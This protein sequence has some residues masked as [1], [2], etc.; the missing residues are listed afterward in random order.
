MCGVCLQHHLG[1]DVWNPLGLE[2]R[3]ASGSVSS[4][5]TA[6]ASSAESSGSWSC[7]SKSLVTG[8]LSRCT[9]RLL[10]CGVLFRTHWIRRHCYGHGTSD[11]P[12]T[13]S[14]ITIAPKVAK[15][16]TLFMA[17]RT[18]PRQRGGDRS[19]RQLAVHQVFMLLLWRSALG[20]TQTATLLVV[21]IRGHLAICTSAENRA[22]EDWC[23]TFKVRLCV[24]DV[25][26]QKFE[27]SLRED[28][29]R[30]LLGS[31][32]ASHSNRTSGAIVT[33]SPTSSFRGTLK[34]S[35]ASHRRLLVDV[36]HISRG[37]CDGQTLA[38]PGRWPFLQRRCLSSTHWLKVTNSYIEFAQTFR[39]QLNPL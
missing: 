29:F 3:L 39:G 16:C 5:S 31:R 37:L 13:E 21:S 26:I 6:P 12:Y 30:P 9:S 36:G 17:R 7:L 33:L 38:S 1:P 4:S 35:T 28:C 34:N 23:D 14:A 11:G 19:K 25:A 22:T 27:D 2:D 24:G 10:S 20:E 8:D 15:T 18:W 32:P